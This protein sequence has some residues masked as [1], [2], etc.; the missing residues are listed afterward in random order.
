LGNH[1]NLHVL[2][3]PLELLICGEESS[4]RDKAMTSIEEVMRKM[5]DES[6]TRYFVPLINKLA[7]KDWYTSRSSAAALIA[8]TFAR[9]T[10]RTRKE[11][12][13]VL[14]KLSADDTSAVRRAVAKALPGVVKVAPP[15]VQLEMIE[16]LK[17]LSKD[18]QDSIRIQAIA[19]CAVFASIATVEQKAQ[20]IILIIVA[21]SSDRS[22]RVRWSLCHHLKD[23]SPAMVDP[24]SSGGGGSTSDVAQHASLVSTLSNVYENLLN[25]P[26]PEVRAAA[27]LH[28]AEVCRYIPKSIL[29][30]KIVPT[31]QRLAVDNSDF[32]RAVVASEVSQLSPF[33]GKEDTVKL[34]LPLLL[35]LLRDDG[36]DVRLNVISH[37]DGINGTIGVELLSQSLLPAIVSL[38]QDP[39]WRVRLAVIELM[40][41][42]A[43]Q[44][45]PEIFTTHLI[46][47]AVGWLG[48]Q[49]YT[50]RQAGAVN[51]RALA[52]IFG[53]DWTTK[54]ILPRLE[55][56]IGNTVHYQRITALFAAQVLLETPSCS[57]SMCRL[58]VP[59]VLRLAHDPVANV[60]L[61][62]AKLLP[63]PLR[64]LPQADALRVEVGSVLKAMLTDGDRD[65]RFYARQSAG[66]RP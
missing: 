43:K 12:L 33:L 60:R 3:R 30:S 21:L 41:M 55:K 2:L 61:T 38:A 48:D 39:K 19:A 26:E 62:L 32:V 9:I 31:L 27:G 58:L 37:L 54:Q 42:I 50:I 36:C 8:I 35:S 44:L 45:G 56:L 51:L 25:D 18:D 20:K 17:I 4:I 6:V 46:N 23:I 66:I 49:I 65:V 5:T 29:L 63:H 7:N 1:E 24:S 10:D 53:E 22:W 52:T 64:I 59:L 34:L 47:V 13:M 16:L 57:L 15:A 14:H 40:P 28:L 11:L